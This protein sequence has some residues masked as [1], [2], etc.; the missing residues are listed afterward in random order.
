M[1]KQSGMGS[2]SAYESAKGRRFRARWRDEAGRQHERRGFPT[3]REARAYVTDAETRSGGR[4]TDLPQEA[5][6]TIHELA[7][8]WLANKEQALKP[9]SFAPI[10]TAWRVYVAPRW[11]TTPVGR[12]RP[13]AVENWIRELGQGLA[14]T[15]RVRRSYAGKP[16]SASVVFRSVGVLAG[17]LDVAVRDGRIRSNPARAVTNMPRREVIVRRPYLT[18]E[19]VFR[20]AGCA[21]D[22]QR[23]T[24][25]LTLAYTGIRWGEAV[26]LTVGDVDLSVR[27][28]R[29]RRAATEVSG[30]ILV[31]TPKSWQARSVPFPAFLGPRLGELAANKDPSDLIFSNSRGGFLHRPDTAQSRQSWWLRALNEAGVGRV[32]PH[33][34]KHTAASLAVSAGA[35]VK[36]LQRILGHKSAA[37]TLDTYADLFEEDLSD[38]A[39]R[40]NERV[41][42]HLGPDWLSRFA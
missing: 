2:V 34:L 14:V 27:R 21:P 4:S 7:A 24:L 39:N 9:S 28:L 38:V 20:F 25:I 40:L 13:S 37:M 41:L 30:Q 11:A 22:S 10:R 31:G 26:A 8:D 36:A 17:I 35:N 32:T 42:A 33:A 23:S 3:M 5:R 16:R 6:I 15:D 19:Q 18:D 12:V 29:I 1:G